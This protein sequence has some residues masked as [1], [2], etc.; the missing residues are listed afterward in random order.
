MN[1]I[2]KAINDLKYTIP[3]EILDKAFID[4]S[5]HYFNTE[6][7]N[8]DEQIRQRVI[9]PRVLI[10]T[11]LVGGKQAVIPLS[12]LRLE[13]FD[14]L[15]TIVHVPKSVTNNRSIMSVLDVAFISAAMLNQQAG[16]YGSMQAPNPVD[17]GATDNGALM[18]AMAS[19][20]N[21]GGKIPI[22][23]TADAELVGENTV[24]IRGVTLV[25]NMFLRCMLAND[26][27]LNDIHPK[28]IIDFSKLVE[29]A[30][31]SYIYNKLIVRLDAGEIF[32]GAQ[33]GV[34]KTLIESY[35]DSEAN[36][37]D[38][39]EQKWAKITFM[40]D[41]V[42]HRRFLRLQIGSQQ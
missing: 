7:S 17:N 31:K 16:G 22:V 2:N 25:Q 33:L 20:M 37:K 21:S 18:S 1:A 15:T 6:N 39:L 8:V 35:A 28:S 19:V 36:Y 10:D 30:V 4:R 27:E 34:F 11:S 26:D 9:K 38:Y 13:T 42:T 41:H 40:N 29:L 3:R 12:G 23:S 5:F 24:M 14:N 32:G